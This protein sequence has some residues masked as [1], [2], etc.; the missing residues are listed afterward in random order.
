[1]GRNKKYAEVYI[2]IKAFDI[3]HAFDYRIPPHLSSDIDTGRIVQ[4]PFKNRVEVGYIVKIKDKSELKDREIKDILK[5]VEKRSVFNPERLELIHWISQ[6]YIQPLGSV[7]KFFLP[8]GGKYRQ[9]ITSPR[10]SG[11]Q[12][13]FKDYITLNR[14]GYDLIKDKINWKR[15]SSQKKIIDYLVSGGEV[16]KEKLIKDTGSGYSSLASLAGIGAT[17]FFTQNSHWLPVC[18]H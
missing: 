18:I 6:Y 1:M 10:V 8:P 4:V 14:T 3:D 13:K 11:V 15:N 16:L 7:I 2:D 9:A 5:V 17:A 12:L